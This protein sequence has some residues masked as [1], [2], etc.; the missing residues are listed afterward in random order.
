MHDDG[1]FKFESFDILTVIQHGEALLGSAGD[2]FDVDEDSSSSQGKMDGLSSSVAFY[3]D[4]GP[5][6]VGL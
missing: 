2:E 3:Y 4:T 1:R 5:N 6:S